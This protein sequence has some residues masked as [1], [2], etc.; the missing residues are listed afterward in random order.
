MARLQ[1]CGT[2][3]D[4]LGYHDRMLCNTLY[5]SRILPLERIL[6]D[7]GRRLRRHQRPLCC[8]TITVR[9]VI[10]RCMYHIHMTIRATESDAFF[11]QVSLKSGEQPITS[12]KSANQENRL[13]CR[14][15]YNIVIRWTTHYRYWFMRCLTLFVDCANDGLHGRL[16]K[17]SNIGTVGWSVE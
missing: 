5:H 7:Q 10:L 6:G 13:E 3:I 14:W 9:L 11:V 8:Y 4:A 1:W 15:E 17:S 2:V 16:K 12:G